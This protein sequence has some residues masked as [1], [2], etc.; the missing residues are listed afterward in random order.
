MLI[1]HKQFEQSD[2][3]R[4]DFVQNVIVPA[5]CYTSEITNESEFKLGVNL[6]G[7]CLFGI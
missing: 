2:Q 7:K 5:Q 3:K 1:L 6:T 4:I